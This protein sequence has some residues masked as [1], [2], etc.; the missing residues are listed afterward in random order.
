MNLLPY[1]STRVVRLT[2]LHNSNGRRLWRYYSLPPSVTALP[3]CASLDLAP[4]CG[5]ICRWE[6]EDDKEVDVPG[7]PGVI[8]GWMPKAEM[9]GPHLR[10][11]ARRKRVS[12]FR[13]KER[14]SELEDEED[15]NI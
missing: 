7:G 12:A 1:S 9:M 10:M 5:K 13:G 2:N 15:R 8:S 6:I 4:K 11:E 14:L 3:L